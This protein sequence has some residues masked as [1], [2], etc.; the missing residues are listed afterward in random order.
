[1]KNQRKRI[2]LR[3]AGLSLLA[4]VLWGQDFKVY[5]N[6][7]FSPGDKIVFEDDFRSTQDG[8]FPVLWDLLSGQGVVNR[9][10]GEPVFA[11]TEGNYVRVAPRVKSKAY[12]DDPFTVE[13]DFYAKPGGYDGVNLF[14]KTDDDDSK[15][16]Y[17]GPEVK[18][19]YFENDLSA[20]IS[21]AD[22][23]SFL[24]VWHHAAFIYAKDQIKC[25]LD[26]SRVLVVPHAGF[27]PQAVRF[28]GIA[29]ADHPILLRNI[30]I[31]NGGG[32]NL[33]DKLT[34]DGRI[35]SHGILFDVGKAVIKPPSMGTLNQVVKLM[36]Q[37]P[38][39]K[40]EVGGHTDSDG[41]AAVNQKLSE[42]RAEAVRK[43]L[44]D[45]G[46]DGSRLTA[47]GYGAGKPIDSNATDEGKANNRRVE[48]VKL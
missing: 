41:D 39:L 34:K 42:A 45:L 7:D 19:G 5:Q 21:P 30:R 24:N 3:V 13:F 20:S 2:F 44:M 1:M 47:K 31:A 14:F 32:M 6:Y 9:M 33:L 36:Q 4:F 43:A 40:L 29:D 15:F 22:R 11:L 16:I 10:N 35:V 28:G 46:I 23:E 48:F 38:G 18:T 37:N 26:Q 27:K 17:F 8:E 12:L 25:Y